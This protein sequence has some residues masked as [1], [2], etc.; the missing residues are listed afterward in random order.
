MAGTGL[1]DVFGEADTRAGSSSPARCHIPAYYDNRSMP[2]ARLRPSASEAHWERQPALAATLHAADSWHHQ[3]SHRRYIPHPSEGSQQRWPHSNPVSGGGLPPEPHDDRRTVNSFANRESRWKRPW[4]LAQTEIDK[5]QQQDVPDLKLDDIKFFLTSRF[6]AVRTGF[7]HLDFFQDGKLSKTEWQEGLYNLFARST[8]DKYSKYRC[9]CTPKV[10]F[11]ERMSML[12]H[13]LD[14]D[15]DGT[16]SF[17]DLTAGHVQPVEKSRD[18]TQRRFREKVICKGE[19]EV[20]RLIKTDTMGKLDVDEVSALLSPGATDQAHAAELDESSR[21]V[22]SAAHTQF[23]GDDL[24][25]ASQLLRDFATVLLQKYPNIKAAFT[26]IDASGNGQLSKSEF[27]AGCQPL[28]FSGDLSVIFSEMDL[29]ANGTISEKEFKVIRQV[30]RSDGILAQERVLQSRKELVAEQRQKDIISVG[31]LKRGECLASLA[32]T[33]PQGECISSSAG[34]YG[35][36]RSPTGRMDRFKHPEQLPAMDPEPF[37]PEHGPGY[38]K[39][40][41]DHFSETGCYEH[42]VRGSKF[43]LGSNINKVARF[44]QLIPSKGLRDDQACHDAS[45]CTFEGSAP[46]D[47]WKV[48]NIGAVGLAHKQARIGANT[49]VDGSMGVISPKPIGLWGASRVGK[50]LMSTASRGPQ[51]SPSLLR[52]A[53]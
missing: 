10:L 36:Q 52:H 26:A 14:K 45:F 38:L 50:E 47:T 48:S 42:P 2:R 12:F 46:Q 18:F 13:S 49:G 33:R 31:P 20:K 23:Y 40:G 17:E 30:G 1:T 4:V 29:R 7:Y 44:G 19:L 25:S 6:G 51:G 24:S 5:R 16:I 53:C 32:N 35:F 3:A 37:S 22:G 27:L 9:A 15:C 39:K 41:P 43:K 28:N 21:S 34:F 8:A 11:N